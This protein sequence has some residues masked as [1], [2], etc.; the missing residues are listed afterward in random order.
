VAVLSILV[1]A[2][3]GAIGISLYGE[4]V[5]EKDEYSVYRFKTLRDQLKLPRVG[6]R[7][8]HKI[9][10][11]VWKVIE[12]SEIWVQP[13]GEGATAHPVPAIYLRYWK[14]RPD[15]PAGKGKTLSHRYTPDDH[16]FGHYWEIMEEPSSP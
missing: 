11:T 14:P 15:L 6:Q 4:K 3:L 1:T 9:S 12:E 16:S 13:A 8:R 10:G 2:P 7:V 5:L